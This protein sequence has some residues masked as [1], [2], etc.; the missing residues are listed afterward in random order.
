MMRD[1]KDVDGGMA[2][3]QWGM[4][5]DGEDNKGHTKVEFNFKSK[6]KI[7]K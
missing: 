2:R 3:I 5:R 6:N 7:N 4:A 1:D